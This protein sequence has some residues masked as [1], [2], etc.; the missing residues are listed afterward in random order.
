[1]ATPATD[2][3]TLVPRGSD[4]AMTPWQGLHPVELQYIEAVEALHA[5]RKALLRHRIQEW[6]ERNSVWL[7]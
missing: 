6:L 2:E 3:Q 7:P 4:V 1:M 5:A